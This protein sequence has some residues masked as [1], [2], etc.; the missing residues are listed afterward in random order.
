[1]NKPEQFAIMELRHSSGVKSFILDAFPNLIDALVEAKLDGITDIYD[2]LPTR[3]I[4][5]LDTSYNPDEVHTRIETFLTT[6][7]PETSDGDATENT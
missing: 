5:R 6:A 1:M 3:V 4:I 7:A 2:I